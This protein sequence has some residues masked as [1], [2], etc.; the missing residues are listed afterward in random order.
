MYRFIDYY[1]LLDITPDSI[2]EEIISSFMRESKLWFPGRYTSISDSAAM[3]AI[4]DA[5]RILINPELKKS[6]DR[7]Y[8]RLKTQ[9]K[10][11]K[12]DKA[13][14]NEE[15]NFWLDEILQKAPRDLSNNTTLPFATPPFQ[16]KNFYSPKDYLLDDIKLKSDEEIIKNYLNVSKYDAEFIQDI[17][18]EIKRRNIDISKTILIPTKKI[19]SNKL[20]DFIHKIFN[21]IR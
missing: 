6:Y 14:A 13:L 10:L 20:I 5:K 9:N 11:L 8:H 19:S 18:Y 1:S 17:I 21:L 4:I 16:Y 2:E 7:E 12:I 3:K 15:G